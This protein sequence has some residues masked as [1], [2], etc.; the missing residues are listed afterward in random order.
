[1]DKAPVCKIRISL[2]PILCY[3]ETAAQDQHILGI[4]GKIVFVGR[5]LRL[6]TDF[7]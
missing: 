2:R 7:G 3:K 4:P 1:M 6:Y 5:V